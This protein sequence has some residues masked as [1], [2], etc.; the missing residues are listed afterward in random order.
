M[1]ESNPTF[2]VSA[3]LS[4]EHC[5]PVGRHVQQKGRLKSKGGCVGCVGC[6]GCLG[7]SGCLGLMFWGLVVGFNFGLPDRNRPEIQYGHKP[8]SCEGVAAGDAFSRNTD[9]FVFA[10]RRS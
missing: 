2:G 7:C 4:V 10:L 1:S 8:C 9:F 5:R 3:A 6:V